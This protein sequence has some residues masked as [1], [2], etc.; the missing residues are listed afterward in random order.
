MERVCVCMECVSLDCTAP[1]GEGD[2]REREDRKERELERKRP[3]KMAKWRTGKCSSSSDFGVGFVDHSRPNKKQKYY[4]STYINSILHMQSRTVYREVIKYVSG[5]PRQSNKHI[6]VHVGGRG[7]R[8]FP[9]ER[10][11]T[12]SSLGSHQHSSCL[13]SLSCR[14]SR[15]YLPPETKQ[16]TRTNRH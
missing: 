13:S 7:K 14:S 5:S 15:S 10:A 16:G 1:L 2:E 8:A 6:I 9:P 12:E 11:S 3:K 4:T